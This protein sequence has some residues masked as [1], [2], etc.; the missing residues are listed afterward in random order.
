[1]DELYRLKAREY[2]STQQ[3]P[4]LFEDHILGIRPNGD[5]VCLALDGTL[6]WASGKDYRFGLGPMMLVD[7][8]ILAMDDFGTITMAEASVEA[9]K[10]LG[11]FA[12]FDGH[13]AWGPFATA[14]TR[15]ICRD[16]TTMRCFDFGAQ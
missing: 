2:G 8:L 14:G 11:R 16:F 6:V 15:V 12:A 7:G 9:F 10:P 5:L 1:M 3:T 13:D 4:V